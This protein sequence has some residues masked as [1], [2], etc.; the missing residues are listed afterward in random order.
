MTQKQIAKWDIQ[1]QSKFIESLLLGLPITLLYAV[2]TETGRFEIIDGAERL[3]ALYLFVANELKLSG[4][5]RLDALN[6]FSFNDL[7]TIVKEQLNSVDIRFIV[8]SGDTSQQLQD[9]IIER[10]HFLFDQNK[11]SRAIA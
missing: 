2:E 10:V 3:H 11:G 9:D 6:D 4:L 8:F 5:T 1:K 7:S